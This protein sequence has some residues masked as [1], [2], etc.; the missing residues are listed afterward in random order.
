[1]IDYNQ[2]LK[3]NNKN[4]KKK[5]LKKKIKLLF[6]FNYFQ[7]KSY[8]EYHLNEKKISQTNVNSD[9]DQIYQQISNIKKNDKLD[10][11]IIGNEFNYVY[12]D[13]KFKIT[14]FCSD[15]SNQIELIKSIKSKLPQ[16]E[17]I[18]FNLPYLT[19]EN[20]INQN[21]S[22]I[23]EI[24]NNFNINLSKKCK[25]YN[26]H[27]FDYN[28]TIL[29]I[30]QNNFYSKKNYYLSKSLHSEEGCFEIS[31]EISKII[32]SIFFV[33]K[34]CLVLDLDNTLWGG[35]LGEDGINGLKISNSYE[36]EKFSNFQKYLKNLSNSGI[37]LAIASKNNLNDVKNVFKMNKNLILK[38]QDFS[39]IKANWKPKFQNLNEIAS[40]LNIGKDAIVFFDDSK[41]ERDQMIKFNP[42]INVIDVPTEPGNYINS[43]EDT[44]YFYTNRNLTLEDLKKK[45]H[46][47]LNKKAKL[48]KSKFTD[49]TSYLK[50]LSMKLTISKI[51]KEN[52]SRCIQMINKTNQFN[53]TTKRYSDLTF[54]N[55][56]KN[57]KIISFVIKLDDKFGD[58][59]IT[60]LL[61]AKILKDKCIIENFLLS[62]R[63]LGRN[64]E[65]TVL[66]ELILKLK[67][68]KIKMLVGIYKKTQKN[69]Q[70]LN[71]YTQNGFLK[72]DKENFILDLKKI[73]QKP[74]KIMSIKYE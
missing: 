33:R 20:Y 15:L 50:N 5:Y 63:I 23:N 73:E 12:Q 16:I 28:S 55:Y 39:I 71:F 62:C 4:S 25:K 11:L 59:G 2:I 48:F 6:N 70:C 29:N 22:K 7:L 49:T 68:S 65:N 14:N 46:Y 3:I 1:M 26:F 27:L 41:F 40:E 67:K 66:N 35:I 42:E 38:L 34:K 54:K 52:F 43:I 74:I 31:K 10:L 13:E 64:I 9:F 17:V 56:L 8:L 61:T 37:I 60:G 47:E 32:K 18:F 57:N 19:N 58:H 53:L 72:K 69:I 51:N 24:I 21:K 44:A 30:G 45:K 36:G